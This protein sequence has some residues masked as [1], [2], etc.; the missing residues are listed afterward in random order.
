M[1]SRKPLRGAPAAGALAGG[2]P[3]NCR[4]R[5][6]DLI[7]LFTKL[8]QDQVYIHRSIMPKTSAAFKVARYWPGMVY[9]FT[10]QVLA[11]LQ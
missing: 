3:P 5:L 1:R 6:V 9:D 8:L 7:S 4:N 11:H 2:Q 10:I